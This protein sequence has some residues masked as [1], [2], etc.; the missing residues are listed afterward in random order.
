MSSLCQVYFPSDMVARNKYYLNS[1]KH[2]TLTFFSTVQHNTHTRHGENNIAS[3]QHSRRKLQGTAIFYAPVTRERHK[4]ENGRE[5]S[6][7]TSTP[8]NTRSILNA[9]WLSRDRSITHHP[10]PLTNV[11]SSPFQKHICRNKV[12][13]YVFLITRYTH[14]TTDPSLIKFY[15]ILFAE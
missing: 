2:L 7:L 3:P 5:T 4:G 15:D 11:F 6:S 1:S 9:I 14:E 8:H 12:G 13:V 10:Q